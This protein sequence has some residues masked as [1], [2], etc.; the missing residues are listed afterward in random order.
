MTFVKLSGE[1]HF[2]RFNQ[3]KFRLYNFR[4]GWRSI[5][6]NSTDWMYSTHIEAE[7]WHDLYL[8]TSYNPM[9][10]SVM[11]RDVWLDPEGRFYDGEGH[12]LCA[13]YICE[14]L[15]GYTDDNPP[16]AMWSADDFLIRK[17]WVK[18]TPDAM[19]PYYISQGMYERLSEYQVHSIRD[20]ANHWG[21]NSFK[22]EWWY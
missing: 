4:G 18:L 1:P 8:S 16:E 9:L 13:E 6:E 14:I 12:S 7:D 22:K 21:I 20:W 10:A 15:W 19:L 17:G 11:D 3:E 5:D 2:Y